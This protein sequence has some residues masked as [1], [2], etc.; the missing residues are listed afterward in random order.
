M[1]IYFRIAD[2]W[3]RGTTIA[4]SVFDLNIKKVLITVD[5]H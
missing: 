1:L 4:I 2:P 5:K 3:F